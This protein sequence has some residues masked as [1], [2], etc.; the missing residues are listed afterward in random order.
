MRAAIFN[1]PGDITVGERPDPVIEAPTDAVVR[2]TLA[3]VCGS[4]LWY[5]RGE[6][7]KA[8]GAIGHEFMGVVEQVGSAVATLAEGD[9]VIAP[10]AFSDGTCPHCL[11]GVQTACL[12]GGFFGGDGIDGGQG[13]AVRVPLA[14]GTLVKVPEGAYDDATLRSLLAL[15]DVM[16]TGHHAAVSAG[17]KAGDTVAVVGDGAVGLCAVIAAK[18]LGAARIIALSRNP[19]RQALAREFGATD[20]VAERG[21]AGVEAVRALTDGVGVDAALE[22]VGTGESMAT[23]LAIARPGSTVGYVG[24]PHGVEVPITRL[25]YGSVG[26]KGGPAPVRAY[27]P[28]LLEDVLAGRINPG[29][30][31]DFET[32][33]A[34]IAEAYAA[35][36]ERRA[37]K[38]LVRVTMTA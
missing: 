1:G 29:R 37:V 21:E 5:Y 15:T 10:F 18:R 31:F 8:P 30:V 28:E 38:S 2:V 16:G 35:M 9:F 34:H 23:A 19:S 14:D 12:Q 22:C 13:E 36:D 25:F 27:L 11:A 24:V 26:L 6:T 20:I 3:C 4:D 7:P 32:D 33:L 17:M